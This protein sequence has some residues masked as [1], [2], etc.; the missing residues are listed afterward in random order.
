MCERPPA[1]SVPVME[2]EL[3]ETGPSDAAQTALLLPGGA[4]AA[5]MWAEVMAEPALAGVRCIAKHTKGSP[6]RQQELAA[7]FKRNVPAHMR[8]ALRHYLVYMNMRADGAE[9]LCAAGVP[10]WVVHAEK[11]DGKL[12]GNERAVFE[13]C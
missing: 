1:P 11:G 2:W 12:V 4:C 5:R 8:A 10:V 9:R 7:D 6:E 13:A 3:I